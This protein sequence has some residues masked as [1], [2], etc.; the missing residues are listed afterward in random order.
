MKYQCPKCKK[1]FI[2]KYNYEIHINRKFSCKI[3][4]DHNEIVNKIDNIDNTP[5]VAIWQQAEK[6]ML[7]N[8]AEMLPVC[9]I[10][11]QCLICHKKYK[12]RTG[13][14]RHKKHHHQNYEEDCKRI[15]DE[16]VTKQIEDNNKL[17]ME[18]IKNELKLTK[19]KLDEVVNNISNKP[20]EPSV[21]NINNSN[22][23]NTNT[24]T[25]LTFNMLTDFG[26]ENLN[27]LTLEDRRDICSHPSEAV[28]KIIQKVH[29]NKDSKFEMN[30]YLSN[31]RS[32][33]MY[34]I[35]KNKFIAKDRNETMY[36][37][38]HVAGIWI[39]ELCKNE[40]NTKGLLDSQK[41]SLEILHDFLTRYDYN[42][43]D[44]DGNVIRPAHALT[45]KYNKIRS[46]V[47]LILYNNRDVVLANYNKL[48]NENQLMSVA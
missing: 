21:Q 5:T 6:I 11:Y 43:E 47:E 29:L 27:M 15:Y 30:I 38:L 7:P 36:D 8:V 48:M 39:R 25:N 45:E 34:I 41:D 37:V 23:T 31:L 22:N 26:F 20:K 24:N 32:N 42:N 4:E 12:D 35:E 9:L 44:L 28:D 46:G 14:F 13:F 3:E 19:D 2:K 10:K 40:E 1:Y 16:L 18:N 17:E 33:V